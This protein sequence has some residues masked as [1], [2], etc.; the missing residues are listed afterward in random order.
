MNS[1]LAHFLPHKKRGTRA[2]LLVHSTLLSYIFFITALIFTTNFLSYKFPNVL[3]FASNINT[4]DLLKY[5]NEARVKDGDKLLKINTQLSNAAYNKAEDMFSKNYWAHVSSTGKEPWDFI[6]TSG[7]VYVY[8]GENLARDFNNS[9]SVVEA[10]LDSPSHRDNLLSSN[11]DDIGFAVVNGVLDGH[12]TTL[13]VQMF[14]KSKYPQYTA[15][16]EPVEESGSVQEVT[17]V[18]SQKEEEIKYAPK[19]QGEVLPAIDIFNVSRGISISLGAL[20]TLLLS[21]DLWYV[22]RQGILRISGNTVA[23]ILFLILALFGIWYAN[24]GIVL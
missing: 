6:N 7:Y 2:K 12:E 24:V 1:L 4:E 10:W 18:A 5:T 3:G 17:G 19:E 20:L 14:G 21:L 23:H 16:I 13:V 22:R 11:Y 9:K 8:A 15:S